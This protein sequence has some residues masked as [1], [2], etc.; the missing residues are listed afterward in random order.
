[1]AIDEQEKMAVAEHREEVDRTKTND[2]VDHV[3][4]SAVGGD[5]ADMP[6]GYYTNWRFIG[7]VAAVS[8]MA[9]GLYLGTFPLWIR[10]I[11][12][13]LTHTTQAMC[14]LPTPLV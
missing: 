2:D 9:Q 7:S 10:S 1:M 3:A 14:F 6:K 13:K 4:A 5:L 11:R 12:S 8:F